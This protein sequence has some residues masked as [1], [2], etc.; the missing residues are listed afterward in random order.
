MIENKREKSLGGDTV[1]YTLPKE[2]SVKSL[3][4]RW[5]WGP[6][7]AAATRSLEELGG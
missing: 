3:E 5:L 7:T 6:V 2:E 1:F 4:S